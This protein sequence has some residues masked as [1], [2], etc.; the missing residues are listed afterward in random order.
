M[1]ICK[2]CGTENR[3][4]AR[5]C[6]SCGVPLPQKKD[7]K[8]IRTRTTNVSTVKTFWMPVFGV[9]AVVAIAGYLIFK[10]IDSGRKLEVFKE[11]TGKYLSQDEQAFAGLNAKDKGII[12]GLSW[13]MKLSDVKKLYP[14]AKEAKDPDFL[15]SLFVGQEQLK[16]IIPHA[17]FMSLG[18][19]EDKLY[20]IKF[21]LGSTEKAQSQAIEV[22]NAEIILYAR[23]SGLYKAF[24]ILYGE[25][26][27]EKNEVEKEPLLKRPD[28]IKSGTNNSYVFWVIGNTKLEL[29][30]FGFQD[31]VKLTCRLLYMPVWQLV[32][33][34]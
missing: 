32:G 12:E 2:A 19:Y 23:F 22:P 28:I 30:L 13:D 33:K 4:E 31:Q 14:F 7:T 11:Y 3:D 26:A 15:S 29:V 27:F 24:K 16:S 6:S 25:P 10:Q 18:I 1:V 8:E 5:F 34:E 17:N 20:G 21:E 9:I